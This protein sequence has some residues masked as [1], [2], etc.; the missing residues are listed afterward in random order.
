[1]RRGWSHARSAQGRL[2][3]A[4]AT[5]SI[6][7]RVI[8]PSHAYALLRTLPRPELWLRELVDRALD[9]PRGEVQQ[10]PRLYRRIVVDRHALPVAVALHVTPKQSR[11]SPSA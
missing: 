5:A 7:D 9:I 2:T 8:P 3:G 4:W 1:L 6:R 11:L 10:R